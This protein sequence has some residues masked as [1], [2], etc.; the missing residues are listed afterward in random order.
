MPNDRGGGLPPKICVG[1]KLGATTI[2]SDARSS[3][4]VSIYDRIVTLPPQ[5]SP[6]IIDIYIDDAF[7]QRVR[8]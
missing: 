3:Y 5:R 7:Y 1:N 8:W 6:R 2:S 4:Q